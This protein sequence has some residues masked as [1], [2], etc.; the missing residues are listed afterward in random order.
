MFAIKHNFQRVHNS[1]FDTTI[2]YS[3]PLQNRLIGVACR[4]GTKP[5][6]P[7]L[8]CEI[9]TQDHGVRKRDQFDSWHER[10]SRRCGNCLHVCGWL[11]QSKTAPCSSFAVLSIGSSKWRWA[12][13]WKPGTI[14]LFIGYN[15]YDMR[16]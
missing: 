11:Y 14:K 2:H 1:S 6:V 16:P 8:C 7:L 10:S 9:F 12:G 3:A 4:L 13:E 5:L 15:D